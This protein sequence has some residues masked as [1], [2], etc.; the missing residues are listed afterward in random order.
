[1]AASSEVAVTVKGPLFEES[2]TI[3]VQEGTKGSTLFDL[4]QAED[5]YK[6]YTFRSVLPFGWRAAA[7]KSEVTIN[8]ESAA[9]PGPFHFLGKR[10]SIQTRKDHLYRWC[11]TY[12]GGAPP[13]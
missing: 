3:N 6:N 2:L 5:N 12:I 8:V 11:T 10:P 7:P 9:A 4:L 13:I 1:M